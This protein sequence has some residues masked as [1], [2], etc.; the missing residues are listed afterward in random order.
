MQPR[1]YLPTVSI[2]NETLVIS[3]RDIIRQ[4]TNILRLKK[5]DVFFVFTP[6]TEYELALKA[7]SN[8]IVEATVIE[9]RQAE[10][11]PAKKLILYQSL[12]KKDKFEWILQKGVELGIHA[13]VPV[14]SDNSIARD[15][16]DNKLVRYHKIITEATEQCGGV[17]I[18]P[19]DPLMKFSD[20]VLRV[21]QQTGQKLIAWEGQTKNLLP[22][23]LDASAKVFHLFIGPEGG[24][25]PAEIE[26]AE[27]NGLT[28]VNL[29]KRI[30]RAETASIAA[31]AL[32]LLN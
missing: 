32:I 5:D 20:A 13:F 14:V 23:V 24:Y 19:L 16:S 8:S 25:S 9:Q 12:L 3:D 2:E 7:V 1:F 30:L 18:A 15:I 17:H 29:G 31:A 21:A 11:E 28:T 4:I 10:R 6:Q 22:K 26:F 27:Q